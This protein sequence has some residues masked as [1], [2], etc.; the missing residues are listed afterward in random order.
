MALSGGQKMVT[1]GW[2]PPISKASNT[3]SA[4]S[5]RNHIRARMV[6]GSL[7]KL[8]QQELLRHRFRPQPA[9]VAYG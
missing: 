6:N 2:L 8:L 9:L 4:N 7:Q 1:T 3:A 5:S